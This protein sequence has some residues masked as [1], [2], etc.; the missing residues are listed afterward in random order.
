MPT[1]ATAK[2]ITGLRWI[3]GGRIAAFQSQR[4]YGIV[5]E[6]GQ[7]LSTDGVNPSTWSTLAIARTIADCQG[8]PVQAI[9]IDQA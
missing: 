8:W 5:N 2:N 6:A 4:A 1:A 3:V 7:L 9:W